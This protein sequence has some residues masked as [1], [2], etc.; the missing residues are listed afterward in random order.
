MSQNRTKFL[1]SYLCTMWL[2]FL[3]AWLVK[4]D[5]CLIHQH[6]IIYACLWLSRCSCCLTFYTSTVKTGYRASWP[7]ESRFC[8]TVIW[9]GQKV[10]ITSEPKFFHKNKNQTFWTCEL[11]SLC[12]KTTF[13]KNNVWKFKFCL[14]AL[15]LVFWRYFSI[16][17][18]KSEWIRDNPRGFEWIRVN[19]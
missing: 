9:A 10:D 16:G 12:W 1:T 5:W 13:W 14:K 6:V 3:K 11:I 2:K 8:W 17:Q 7:V 19:S 4:R 18:R 15:I